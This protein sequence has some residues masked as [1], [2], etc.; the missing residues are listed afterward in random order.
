[1]SWLDKLLGRKRGGGDLELVELRTTRF[2]QLLRCYGAFLDLIADAA[3]KQGGD[4]ILDR[5]Y[6]ISLSER[7][8]DL[9]ESV[10]FDLT[11]MAGDRF[12]AL[13]TTVDRLRATARESL[14]RPFESRPE[15][16]AGP[17]GP[18]AVDGDGTPTALAEVLARAE[19]LYRSAGVVVCRGIAAGPVVHVAPGG[20]GAPL[21]SGCVLVASDG[22]QIPGFSDLMRGAAAVLLDRG[23]TS[24]EVASA[25]RRLRVPTIVGFGDATL[26]LRAGEV[27][28]VDA[29]DGSVYRGRIDLLLGYYRSRHLS[30]DDEPEYRL[31][32]EVRRALFPLTLQPDEPVPPASCATLTDLVHL[33]HLE[34]GAALAALLANHPGVTSSGVGVEVGGGRRM[35]VLDLGGAVATTT[36][37]HQP[38]GA[39]EIRNR[40]LAAFVEG[41]AGAAAGAHVEARS[42]ATE[43]HA[44]I[45][46]VG[47]GGPFVIDTT[48]TADRELNHLYVRCGRDLMTAGDWEA[49][50]GAA[51][52]KAGGAITA[53][54]SALP[55]EAME[56]A[57]RAA[58]RVVA[59]AA[60]TGADAGS[61]AGAG[62]MAGAHG[63]DRLGSGDPRT[64]H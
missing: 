14:S 25:A 44:L 42:A 26:K 54:R 36:A 21:P 40:A 19:T 6:V 57:L 9:A 33:A 41:L 39:H 29:D 24:G 53:W 12:V 10:L 63:R 60:R 55:A 30:G 31:L 35:R 5:Q 46:V 51:T 22:D 8:L 48:L 64:G 17:A 1:M 7:A 61:T 32:R 56:T 58:A 27:V 16:G 28:T 37:G 23:A 20:L 59:A 3:E 50:G 43:E 47:T 15:G 49:M 2:R 4:F 13:Q 52:V 18:P 45:S 11:V 62:A 34:A 38:A